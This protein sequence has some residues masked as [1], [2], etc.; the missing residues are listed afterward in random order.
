[1]T[2]F[3]LIRGY[4]ESTR[5]AVLALRQH[6]CK[7]LETAG[8]GDVEEASIAFV[9]GNDVVF[10]AYVCRDGDAGTLTPNDIDLGGDINLDSIVIHV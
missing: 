4:K 3:E 9:H 6:I 1:M 8:F 2:T 5:T 7:V 10:S